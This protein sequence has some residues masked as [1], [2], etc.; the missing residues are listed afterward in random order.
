MKL[1]ERLAKLANQVSSRIQE[2][3][4]P[5]PQSSSYDQKRIEREVEY[6]QRVQK[7]NPRMKAL[8][9]RKRKI[10]QRRSRP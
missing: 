8:R 2:S 4:K 7:V 9:D 6:M 5:K 1:E 3:Q 10:Q